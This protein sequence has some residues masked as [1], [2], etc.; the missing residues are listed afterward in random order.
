MVLS[1]Q[2]QIEQHSFSA[3]AIEHFS[4]VK[5]IPIL[6][7]MECI[8]I[9]TTRHLMFYNSQVKLEYSISFLST[10]QKH[11]FGRQ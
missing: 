2:F 7:I 10:G 9:S 4:L 11:A 8:F 5:G 1:T 3:V 6:I